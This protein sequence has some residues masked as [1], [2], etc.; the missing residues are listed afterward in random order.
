M[1]SPR[2]LADVRS[3][4]A[5]CCLI[6]TVFCSLTL[7]LWPRELFARSERN[8]PLSVAFGSS[9]LL[10]PVFYWLFSVA[11][12]SFGLETFEP[13]GPNVSLD[14]AREPLNPRLFVPA[15]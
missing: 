1:C 8:F 7:G 10:K 11:G 13:G 4:V 12:A 14:L 6:C 15:P 2:L 9:F 3:V 5:S